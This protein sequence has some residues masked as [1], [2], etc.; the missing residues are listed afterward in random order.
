MT[1]PLASDGSVLLEITRR[2]YSDCPWCYLG[3]RKGSKQPN[4]PYETLEKRLEWAY[5]FVDCSVICLLGGE[6]LL[7]PNLIKLIWKIIG[8]GKTPSIITSGRTSSISY[9][10]ENYKKV[11]ELYERG[12]LDIEISYHPGQNDKQYAQM[13][14]DLRSR[15]QSRRQALLEMERYEK[16]DYDLTSTVVIDETYVNDWVKFFSLVETLMIIS[17]DEGPVPG[18]VPDLAYAH[19]A[20]RKHFAPYDESRFNATIMNPKIGITNFRAK[21]RLVGKIGIEEITPDT[22]L[23]RKPK[24]GICSAMEVRLEGEQIVLPSALIRVDGDLCFSR[25]ECIAASRGLCN[26]DIHDELSIYRTVRRSLKDIK[27]E[28]ITAKRAT[29]S[30]PTQYCMADRDYPNGTPEAEE[31]SSCQFDLSCNACHTPAES[32]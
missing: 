20:F 25:P 21:I 15:Y 17:Y 7:H 3:S 27:K 5:Q 22:F 13:V 9:E 31:C 4:V 10:Q 8:L 11:L 1:K 26:V 12:L 14:A 28:I 23:V 24:G 6:P 32:W 18:V 19:A 29:A 2:C 30:S 16:S